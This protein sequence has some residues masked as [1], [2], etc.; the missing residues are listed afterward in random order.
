MCLVVT[1][2]EKADLLALVCGGHFPIGIL[3]QV[4]Y[5]IVSIPD[6][7]TLTYLKL[8]NEESVVLGYNACHFLSFSSGCLAY[9]FLLVYQPCHKKVSESDLEMP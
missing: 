3:G 7:C 2:W 9:Y 1:C 6:L 4:W 8:L 5:L